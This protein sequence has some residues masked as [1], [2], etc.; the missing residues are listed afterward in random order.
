MNSTPETS[1]RVGLGFVI[2]TILIDAIGVGIVFPIMPDLMAEVGATSTADAAMLGGVLFASYAL[3]QFTFSPLIGNLSDAYGRRPV[4]LIALGA[5]VVDYLIMGIAGTFWLLLVGRLLAGV[6][7][8][9]YSTA[10]AYLADISPPDKRAANFGIIGAA[11]GIGFILGPALAGVVAEFDT[12]APFFLA[13]ALAACNFVYG[14]FLLPESLKPSKRR[15]FTRTG[16][17]PLR[18]LRDAVRLKDLRIPLLVLFF[19]EI[20]VFVYPAVWSYFGREVYGWS[21]RT[22]GLSLAAFGVSIALVQ[23]VLIRYLIPW[24][25]EARTAM[26]GTLA[27]ISALIG[28]GMAPSEVW[29]FAL[30][31]VMA[32]GDLTP[33]ALSG[34][35][36]NRVGEDRQ[37]ILQGV[38]S[39]IGAIQSII[40]P[41][42]M[43]G[44]FQIFADTKGLYLPGAPF[45]LG[46]LMLFLLLPAYRRLDQMSG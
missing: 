22:I 28:V 15:K 7:G 6:A 2:G 33:P 19:F 44:V 38:L 45:L 18:A 10:S 23:G 25:G 29:V 4:L 1:Y 27:A 14:F 20:A 30:I 35:L 11:F 16:S 42:V 5:L 36:S 21:A 3:M 43:T 32:L 13:A 34:M 37:G 31:P 46:A 41:V 39:S 40:G 8:A 12:R 17:N 24:L 9:T 26:L